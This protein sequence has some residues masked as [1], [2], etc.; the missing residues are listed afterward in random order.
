MTFLVQLMHF[1]MTRVDFV[2]A[3][4]VA[5]AA[6]VDIAVAHLLSKLYCK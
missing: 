6:V 4:V 2:V 3:T 1:L 5:I